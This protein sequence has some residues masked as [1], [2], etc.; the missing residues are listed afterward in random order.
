MELD[1]Q[2]LRRL[3]ALIV[4]E[5]VSDAA[6]V[7]GMTQPGMSIA[8][9]K[10]RKVLGDSILTRVRGR[11]VVTE[12]AKMLLPE[13]REILLRTRALERSQVIFNPATSTSRF[14]IALMDSVAA[15]L[16]PSLVRRLT[17]EAPNASLTCRDSHHDRVTEWFDDGEI[18]LGIGYHPRP[19]THLH[20]RIIFGDSWGLVVSASHPFARRRPTTTQL[21]KTRLIRIS[22]AA[23]D[24]YWDLIVAAMAAAGGSPIVGPSVPSFLVAAHTAAETS[25]VAAMPMRLARSLIG[26]LPIHVL[27]IPLTLPPLPFGMRWHPRTHSSPE[28]RWFRTLAYACSRAIMVPHKRPLRNV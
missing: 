27:P 18:H 8:L 21:L 7:M 16:M 26:R 9:A 14:S 24:A 4:H 10:L 20:A 1:P 22:P 11:M 12:H 2:M 23:S 5:S 19:P 25:L 6:A 28:H 13:V 15:L 3:E 17:E